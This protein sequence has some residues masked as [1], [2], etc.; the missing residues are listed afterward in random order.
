MR[1]IGYRTPSPALDSL[2]AFDMP[3]PTPAGRDLLIEVRAVSVNPVDYKVASGTAPKPGGIKVVGYDAAGVVAEAGPEARFFKQGD[4]VFYAGSIGRQGAN[5]EYHLVDERIVGEKPRSLDFPAAAALPLTSIT[6]WEAMFDR[7]DVA[8]DVPGAGRAILIVGG[9]G[10]V[11]SIAIQLARQL[12]DLAV[13]ATA[14]RPETTQWAK[15]M[16]AHYVV[17]HSKPLAPQV[18]ALGIGAPAFIFATVPAGS[19]FPDLAELIAPQGRIALINGEAADVSPFMRKSVAV[20]YEL[21]FTRPLFQ[22]ADI[23]AQHRLLCEL[24]DLVDAGRVRTT[25]R[26]HYGRIDAANLMRAFAFL[27]SGRAV[28]KIVLAGF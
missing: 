23:E 18:A 21:M 1:A 22:T 2:E 14:S 24:A 13:A 5:A 11:G 27:R 16:G 7:L 12:T 9:A 17:D 25:M 20:C 3:R 6:A 4:E 19:R 28:G 15:E 26:E 8:R 10:G